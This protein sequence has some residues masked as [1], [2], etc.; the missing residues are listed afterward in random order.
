VLSVTTT[1]P[2]AEEAGNVVDDDG[3]DGAG[4][5]AGPARARGRGVAL[6]ACVLAAVPF[7][8]AAVRGVRR[9]WEPTG[10]DA[11]SAIRAWDVFSDHRPLLGTW[12]SVSDS[13]GRP[14]NHPGPLH[15]DLLAVPVRL[16][17]HAPG[18]ALGTALVNVA[19]VLAV[20]WLLW[21]RMGPAAAALGAGSCALLAWSMGSELLYEPWSQ[22]AP[23]WPFTLFLVA[24][25]CAVAGDPVA[26]PVMVVAGSVALQTHLSYSLLVPGL[27]GLAVAVC[28]VRVLRRRSTDP[29]GWPVLRR[30]ARRWGVAVVATVLVTWSQPLVENFT[31]DGEGNLRA[32]AGSADASLPN[33]S[34]G[35][36][37]RVLGSTVAVPPAWLPPSWAS[38]G[39]DGDG[40]GRPLLLCVAA[41]AALVAGLAGLGWRAWRRGSI[42]V[43]AGCAVAL[44]GLVLALA[45][46]LRASI[47]WGMTP[48]YVRWMW[49]LG[50][51]VW[52]VL[53]LAL[54]GEVATTRA[55]R[56]ARAGEGA[57]EPASPGVPTWVRAGG[58]ALPG[59]VLVVVAAT[60]ALPTVDNGVSSPR[61]V[62]D[63]TAALHD[64]VRAAVEGRGPVLVELVE[65]VAIMQVGPSVFATMQEAGEP[66]LVADPVLVRQLGPARRF[67]PGEADWKLTVRSSA[68]AELAPG[69][70]LVTQW[71]GEGG[72]IRVYLAPL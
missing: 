11:Y 63:A 65:P 29:D 51:V 35:T 4:D 44:A 45:S 53:A 68:P 12:S 10:D 33:P 2:L 5:P 56:R 23:L 26:L 57:I 27:G 61:W 39:F 34:L 42:P 22:Y 28:V 40:G 38:P 59:L 14:I 49:P 30:R 9:G 31:G 7:L 6:A 71:E 36:A 64:D 60:A 66:F 67:D 18:T 3:Q 13:I 1:E 17:G 20:G 70:E 43:A 58:W 50:M 47:V 62:S 41:L 46:V 24:V 21:R 19:A 37:L 69:E 32:L 55:V 54:A 8:V 52:L 48:N 72:V 16:L 15:F 25:W